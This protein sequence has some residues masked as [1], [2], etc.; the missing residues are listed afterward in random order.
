MPLPETGPRPLR[1]TPPSCSILRGAILDLLA[2]LGVVVDVHGDSWLWVASLS[3]SRLREIDAIARSN[4]T[5]W[6]EITL[7]R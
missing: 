2:R 3:E 1:D 5:S 7:S 4:G 6:V